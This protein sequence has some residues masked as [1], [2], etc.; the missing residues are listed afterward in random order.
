M[1]DKP[2]IFLLHRL[3][4]FW[5][6]LNNIEEIKEDYQK[7]EKLERAYCHGHQSSFRD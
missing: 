7:E 6:R 3:L 2:L 1:E 4:F 5:V